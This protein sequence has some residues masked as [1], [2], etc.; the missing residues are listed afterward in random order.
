VRCRYQ[1][2]DAEGFENTGLYA[3]SVV[4]W[5]AV[6]P[7]DVLVNLIVLHANLER[8]VSTNEFDFIAS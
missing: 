7:A 2:V 1:E 5:D 4:D 8:R 6:P 3:D